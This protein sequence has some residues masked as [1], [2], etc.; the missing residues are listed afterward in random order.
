M[1]MILLT[2]FL[3]STISFLLLLIFNY[4]SLNMFTKREK[5][6]PYECGFE[7]ITS[8]RVP[9]SM[10]F[11]LVAVLFLIF[12]IEIAFILPAPFMSLWSQPLTFLSSMNVFLLILIL[13]LLHE[14]NEG[15]LEWPS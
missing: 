2:L 12:D 1:I 10:R 8:A 6:S 9:Y 4:L 3:A 15:S 7:P 5:S 11:F 13:G 14:W